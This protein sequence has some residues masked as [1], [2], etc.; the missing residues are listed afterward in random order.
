MSSGA[1]NR[2]H[3]H[4]CQLWRDLRLPHVGVL[5]S[6]AGCRTVCQLWRDLRLP[7]VSGRTDNH[8][9]RGLLMRWPERQQQCCTGLPPGIRHLPEMI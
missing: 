4:E 1:D 8:D 5:S 7:H 2:D 6:P 9:I 3:N